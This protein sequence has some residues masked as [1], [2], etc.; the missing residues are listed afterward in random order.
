AQIFEGVAGSVLGE[1]ARA[2][3]PAGFEHGDA[4]AGFGQLLGGPASGRSGAH[5]YCVED[6]PR[7]RRIILH[8]IQTVPLEHNWGVR[9]ERVRN[10]EDYFMVKTR[11]FLSIGRIGLR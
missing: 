5:Y 6:L 7:G 8:D 9:R 4:P 11:L 2:D 3:A 1:F 10:L